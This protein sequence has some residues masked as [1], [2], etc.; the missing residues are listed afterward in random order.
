V[1]FPLHHA[2]VFYPLARKL[3]PAVLRR[4]TRTRELER[5]VTLRDRA[6]ILFAGSFRV[7][8]IS[9]RT[10]SWASSRRHFALRVDDLDATVAKLRAR[11][12]ASRTPTRSL[13]GG[14]RT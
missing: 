1:G 12:R 5:P 3:A 13:A 4:D 6:G 7:T 10:A 9:R 2:Q 14:A 11:A 8:C